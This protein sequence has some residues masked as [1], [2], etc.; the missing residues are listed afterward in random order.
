MSA[1]QFRKWGA[2][3]PWLLSV[4]TVADVAAWTV[5]VFFLSK[6]TFYT[7]T[8]YHV[9]ESGLF[10]I[11]HCFFARLVQVLLTGVCVCV[12]FFPQVTLMLIAQ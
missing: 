4:G 5:D 3:V 1:G 11:Q 9:A 6:L 12:F 7:L 2:P 8:Y 10:L